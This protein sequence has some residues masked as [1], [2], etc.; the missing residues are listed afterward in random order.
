M[1]TWEAPTARP[2]PRGLRSRLGPEQP[3][4]VSAAIPAP[5][6]P[7][8]ERRGCEVWEQRGRAYPGAAQPGA[9]GLE[10]A[11]RPRLPSRDRRR[12]HRG[13]ASQR[14][15]SS[16]HCHRPRQAAHRGRGL[17]AG[18]ARSQRQGLAAPNR[19]AGCRRQPGRGARRRTCSG[20]DAHGQ[21]PPVVE[22]NRMGRQVLSTKASWVVGAGPGARV[23]CMGPG[24]EPVAVLT[25]HGDGLVL[26]VA[27]S[28][29]S[30][31]LLLGGAPPFASGVCRCTA[32]AGGS[33]T[34]LGPSS[35]RGGPAPAAPQPQRLGRAGYKSPSGPVGWCS[36]GHCCEPLCRCRCSGYPGEPR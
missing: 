17:C 32:G 10:H 26:L 7:E 1:T 3:R 29:I 24:G 23:F 33:C 28:S 21:R 18:G 35:V 16:V 11:R 4:G 36:W 31:N 2:L 19:R 25:R 14:E 6:G 30:T 27:D 20:Q 22:L 5:R 13:S 34:R 9:P 15:E 8:D 12:G